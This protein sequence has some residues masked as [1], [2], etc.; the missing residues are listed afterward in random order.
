[1]ICEINFEQWISTKSKD[2]ECKTELVTIE[3]LC[4]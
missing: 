2:N 4:D 3:I 1:M